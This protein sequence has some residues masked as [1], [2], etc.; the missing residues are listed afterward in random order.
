MPRTIFTLLILV[1][2][3]GC[4]EKTLDPSQLIGHWTAQK[5]VPPLVSSKLAFSSDGAFQ[6]TET[7]ANNVDSKTVEYGGHFILDDKNK[8]RFIIEKP[9]PIRTIQAGLRFNQDGSLV[10]SFAR[11]IGGAMLQSVVVYNRVDR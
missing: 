6:F 7:Y 9:D 8:L 10:L 11:T 5:P 3:G 1:L 2:L 4:D